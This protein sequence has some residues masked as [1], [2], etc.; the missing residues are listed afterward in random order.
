MK[1]LLFISAFC[2][3]QAGVYA[4]FAPQQGVVG[5]TA[6]SRNSG[7]FT[8]WAT[9]CTVQRGYADIAD[10]S[11]GYPNIG[12]EADATG[13][14]DGTLLSLGDSGVVVL[15]FASP[16]YNGAGA[17]FAVF[18]NGFGNPSDPEDAF[19]ELAFVEVSSDGVNYTRFPA[20]SNTPITPQV[21]GSGVYMNARL[22]NNL[23][24]KYIFG[25]GTPFDL[26]E[27]ENTPG[28]DINNI[29]HVRLIDVVGS[30][31]DHANM[32]KDGNIVNDPYPTPFAGGGFDL[33]AIGAFYQHGK[34]PVAVT[35]IQQ[36]N[37]RIYPNPTT[38]N[39]SISVPDSYTATITDITGKL[40]QQHSL[41]V[42]NNQ[43]SLTALAK[44]SYYL[45]LTDANGNKWAERI[46]KL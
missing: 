8:G 34:F 43:L 13:M 5:S 26:A 24:G 44:G 19:L 39:I 41:A 23:A 9:G 35:G 40:I 28:L 33:D 36:A 3:V 1:K 18:E 10:P 20:T 31:G 21:P 7:A 16:I 14:A 42:G 15:T 46:T 6:V 11:Q 27:L 2:M 4:Q 25:Y 12:V 37:I 17:D 32:D 30:V 22:I 38:D 29:T 45:S